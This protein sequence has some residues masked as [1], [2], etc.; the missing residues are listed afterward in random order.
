MEERLDAVPPL[1]RE[2]SMKKSHL[3]TF[4]VSFAL[5]A[6]LAACGSGQPENPVVEVVTATSPPTQTEFVPSST[7]DP[8]LPG[9]IEAE[10]EKVH[11]FMRE[12]DDASLLAANMPQEQ[13]GDAIANLQKI[14]RDAEDQEVPSCLNTLKTYQIA[15]MN[16]VINTLIAFM[17][18]TDQATVDQGIA[19]ARQQHDDYTLE[20][21]RILGLTV[22]PADEAQTLQ[23]TPT[24]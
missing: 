14:R 24:P 9:N 8:C 3:S 12:F 10:V 7:P 17:G 6:L 23:V 18:D 11:K 5:T 1:L 2:A 22:V 21:A 16:S 4:L 20:L 19:V 13:L 15:H